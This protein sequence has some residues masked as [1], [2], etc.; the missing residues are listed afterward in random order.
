MLNKYYVPTKSW[1]S[2]HK[3]YVGFAFA[4][5]N[6]QYMEQRDIFSPEK[7]TVFLGIL[8]RLQSNFPNAM[9]SGHFRNVQKALQIIQ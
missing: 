6:V 3:K 1:F 5:K 9:S 7:K 2:K 8:G 4:L